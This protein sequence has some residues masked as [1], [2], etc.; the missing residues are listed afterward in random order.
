MSGFKIDHTIHGN[1]LKISR[2]TKRI[3]EQSVGPPTL[4]SPDR[5]KGADPPFNCETS[6]G[7]PGGGISVGWWELSTII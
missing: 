1:F 5:F 2:K 7:R 3:T 4:D 6:Q